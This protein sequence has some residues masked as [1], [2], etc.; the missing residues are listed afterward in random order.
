MPK[1]L[2]ASFG[3]SL[4]GVG[5]KEEK[6]KRAVK[7]ANNNRTPFNGVEMP[8]HYKYIQGGPKVI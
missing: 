4:E 5:Q 6:R 7:G 1:F 2:I 3:L 8:V